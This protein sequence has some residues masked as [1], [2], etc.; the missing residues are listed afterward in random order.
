MDNKERKA[1]KV[2][3]VGAGPGDP[4]LI[5]V[6]GSRLLAEA[7]CIVYDFLAPESLLAINNKAEHICAGKSGSAHTMGQ[8]EI[9][10]L[11]VEKAREGRLVVRLKGGDPF[12]FGRGGEEALALAEQGI[13]FEV[14]PG[15][16]SAS[17]VPAYAGIPVTHRGMASSVS[18][19]TGHEDPTKE[20]SDIDWPKVA[21]LSG[22]LVFLMGVKNLPLITDKLITHGRSPDEAAAV[23]CRGTTSRQQTVTG[24]LKDIASR[25][26][27][28]N[29]K[30]PA[31]FMTGPVVQL[32]EKLAWYERKP[33]FGR[34]FLVTRAREQAGSLSDRLI[35]AGAQVLEIPVIKFIEPDD[36]RSLDESIKNLKNRRLPVGHLHKPQGSRKIF[37]KTFPYRFGF[38]SS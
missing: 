16:S 32:R 22:T 6:K 8:A 17:A 23:I 11:L 2:Y 18:F 21:G 36:F 5:T 33:L 19:I 4:G 10:A 24:T 12:I 35:N 9:N 38:Q 15:V 34:T 30:P 13:E 14:V 29:I 7:D 27:E 37:R 20:K 31:I 28:E 25:A 26:G 1:G 3:L